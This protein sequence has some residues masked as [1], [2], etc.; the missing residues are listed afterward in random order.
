[1]GGGVNYVLCHF[2]GRPSMA[3]WPADDGEG[4]SSFPS[5]PNSHSD[6]PVT[7]EGREGGARRRSGHTHTYIH[8]QWLAADSSMKCS[9]TL[10]NPD[11]C[12]FHRFLHLVETNLVSQFE[13][14]FFCNYRQLTLRKIIKDRNMFF[15]TE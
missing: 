4:P 1:M 9:R 11:D 12:Q 7:S 3:L 14:K 8:T 2:A 10:H 13:F 15:C 5:Q 6:A